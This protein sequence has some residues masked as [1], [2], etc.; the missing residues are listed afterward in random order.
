M[1]QL[2]KLIEKMRRLPPEMTYEEVAKVLIAHGW[3][4][5]R[6]KGSH[7][8]FRHL[9]GR[10]VTIPKVGGKVVKTTYL[11]QVLKLISGE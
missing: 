10:M 6:S 7:H 1:G 4:E 5:V 2:E 11:K 8:V 9:D 3:C